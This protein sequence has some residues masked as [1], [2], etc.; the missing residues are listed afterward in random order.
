MAP[1]LAEPFESFKIPG[2]CVK[3]S[4]LSFA[5]RGVT[6]KRISDRRWMKSRRMGAFSGYKLEKE[7]NVKLEFFKFLRVANDAGN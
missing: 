4:W 3:I 1:E 5:S 2:N 6:R 7:E